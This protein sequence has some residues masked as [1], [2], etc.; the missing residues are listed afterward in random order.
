MA[1]KTRPTAKRPRPR[2]KAKRSLNDTMS[3]LFADV[4]RQSQKALK[5]ELEAERLP[6]ELLSLHF[7]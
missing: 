2:A 6:A 7:R 4:N 1:K 3:K 5:T